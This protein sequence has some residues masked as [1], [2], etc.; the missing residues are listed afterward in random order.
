MKSI[1][2]SIAMP[3]SKTDASGAHEIQDWVFEKRLHTQQVNVWYGLRSDGV[4]GP[5]FFQNEWIALTIYDILSI[6]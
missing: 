3:V 1:S 2:T 5:Y 4:I 6:F